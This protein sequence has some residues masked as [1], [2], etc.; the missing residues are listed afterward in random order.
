VRQADKSGRTFLNYLPLFRFDVRTL[1]EGF[2]GRIHRLL[3]PNMALRYI[4][5]LA[6]SINMV[7]PEVIYPSVVE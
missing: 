5:K 4:A 1:S 6:F 2:P 7:K 3:I